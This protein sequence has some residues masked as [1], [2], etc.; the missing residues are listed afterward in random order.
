MVIKKENEFKK[1]LLIRLDN[2]GDLLMT[3][4]AIRAIKESLRDVELTLLGSPG[5]CALAKYIP[6]IDKT[7]PFDAPWVKTKNFY[8]RPDTTSLLIKKLASENFDASIV[9]SVYSQN[10][11]PGIIVSYLAN[12]PRR[13]AY[14]HEKCYQLITDWVEDHEP[15]KFILHE[16][17]R[18]LNLVKTLGFMTKNTRLSLKIPVER[19]YRLLRILANEGINIQKPWVI[20]HTTAT[21]DKRIYSAEGFVKVAKMFYQKLSYQ[22]IFS[23]VLDEVP[24]ISKIYRSAGE[25]TFLLA[26]KIDLAEFINLIAIS[27]LL[28]SN[29]S[30]PVHIA[31]ALKTPVVDLYSR[32]NPQH[33]PWEVK[34]KVL[35][36][37]PPKNGQDFSLAQ[38]P[39]ETVFKAALELLSKD[40]T[41]S[42]THSRI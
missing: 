6:E 22:V 15:Q 38:V 26:G 34:K 29:N 42:F 30:G 10:P 23:G 5:G 8:P 9:F 21:S 35:Y 37:D 11:I 36:F 19:R 27:P 13:I 17:E 14:C 18:Q 33:L 40:K 1:V 2:M 32:T 12:I 41:L 7:I 28:V 16:V 25:G 24:Y 4:P 3:T 20:L 31:A 39:P